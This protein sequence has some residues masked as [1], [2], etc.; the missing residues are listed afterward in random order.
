MKN[1]SHIITKLYFKKKKDN[2]VSR[3]CVN[4]LEYE[5]IDYKQ[6]KK[7]VADTSARQT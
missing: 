5:T 3:K 1:Q 4:K 7:S 6:G 2:T